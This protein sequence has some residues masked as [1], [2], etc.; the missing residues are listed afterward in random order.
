MS[1]MTSDVPSSLASGSPSAGPKLRNRLAIGHLLLWMATTGVVLAYL[2][3]RQ[4]MPPE[5]I[6]PSSDL[7]QPGTNEKAARE[8]LERRFWRRQKT[9]HTVDLTFA[10]A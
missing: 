4:P 9:K 3:A 8:E 2:Q 1:Q 5:G 6:R 10:P 7:T